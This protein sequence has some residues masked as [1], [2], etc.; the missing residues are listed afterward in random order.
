MRTTLDEMISL[1]Q[2]EK[3]AGVPGSTPIGLFARNMSGSFINMDIRVGQGA[4]AKAEF[5]KGW[6]VAKRVSRGGVPVIVLD[7]A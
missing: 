7:A 5:D 2:K 1:L 6:T 4:V 3:A